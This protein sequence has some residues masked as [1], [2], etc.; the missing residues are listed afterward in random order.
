M[1]KLIAYKLAFLLLVIK[2]VSARP[3]ELVGS[4]VTL[5]SV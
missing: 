3:S 4:E 2:L 1:S 5:Q